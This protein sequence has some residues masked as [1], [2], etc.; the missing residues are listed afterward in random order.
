[1]IT[2]LFSKEAYQQGISPLAN[3]RIQL[4][5]AETSQKVW[6]TKPQRGDFQVSGDPEGGEDLSFLL[7]EKAL[8]HLCE[9]PTLD[10]GD[11][12]VEILKLMLH[13]DADIR[14][15]AQV[16]IGI[17]EMFRKGYFSVLPLGGVKVTRFLAERG[18]T[19]ISRIQDAIRKM[20]G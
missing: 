10:V 11:I 1:V 2:D 3:A 16:H 13:T 12:G 7:T 8:L 17:F 19:S 6:L 18:F 14:I 5:L 15:S 20:R 4:S 9:A